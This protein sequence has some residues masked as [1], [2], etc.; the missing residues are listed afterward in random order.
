MVGFQGQ[1]N[2]LGRNMVRV[3]ELYMGGS[4][5]GTCGIPEEI[6]DTSLEMTMECGSVSSV[7][8]LWNSLSRKILADQASR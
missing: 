6:L 7:R 5:T 1:V 2:E 4:A 3:T 8:P